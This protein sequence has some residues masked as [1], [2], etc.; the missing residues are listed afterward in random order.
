M[1]YG[2][3]FK[4]RTLAKSNVLVKTGAKSQSKQINA[5]ANKV[6]KLEKVQRTLKTWAQYSYTGNVNLTGSPVTFSL[7]AVEAWN[8][9]F[10]DSSANTNAGKYRIKSMMWK[11]TITS[12][13]Q[14]DFVNFSMF[15]VQLRPATATKVLD[16]S[17]QMATLTGDMYVNDSD[18]SLLNPAYFKILKY[19]RFTTS[20]FDNDENTEPLANPRNLTSQFH[21]DHK[22]KCSHLLQC[23]NGNW[24]DEI[25]NEDVPPEARYYLIVLHSNI[26]VSAPKISYSLLVNGFT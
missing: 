15:M 7:T 13:T 19:K 5:L 1:P 6:K 17:N 18:V 25:E 3:R 24:K 22:I 9:L 4:K 2:R 12:N 26:G 16:D 10:Q 14:P 8:P 23:G 11:S 21:F 20:D